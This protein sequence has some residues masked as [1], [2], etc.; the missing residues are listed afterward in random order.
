MWIVYNLRIVVP[1]AVFL[2]R[3][4]FIRI[5]IQL[6]IWIWIRIQRFP[7]PCMKFLIIWYCNCPIVRKVPGSGSVLWIRI[8]FQKATE[9][10]SKYRSRSGVNIIVFYRFLKLRP[11]NRLLKWFSSA[12]DSALSPFRGDKNSIKNVLQLRKFAFQGHRYLRVFLQG[13]CAVIL[14]MTWYRGDKLWA[15]NYVT[16]VKKLIKVGKI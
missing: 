16:V 10:G 8:R 12:I 3:I 5:R 7:L 11:L 13:V 9:Y 14:Y 4:L 1:C 2:I 6:K 15:E